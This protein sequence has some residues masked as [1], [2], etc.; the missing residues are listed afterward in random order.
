MYRRE[1]QYRIDPAGQHTPNNQAILRLHAY[2]DP[3]IPG[4]PRCGNPLLDSRNRQTTDRTRPPSCFLEHRLAIAESVAVSAKPQWRSQ[5]SSL[6]R[7]IGRTRSQTR[8]SVALP[9]RQQLE[10]RSDHNEKPGSIQV[11]FGQRLYSAAQFGSL[12]LH[13]A[14]EVAHNGY[15]QVTKKDSLFYQHLFASADWWSAE[16]DN[17]KAFQTLP[18]GRR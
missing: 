2:S 5:D 14:I 18:A 6:K 9:T 7:P 15:S 1:D 8:P 3:R 10:M 4:D 17:E 11:Q 16:D 12:G 13:N